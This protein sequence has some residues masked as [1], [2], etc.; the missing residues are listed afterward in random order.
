MRAGNKGY[1]T[2][3]S[4]VPLDRP[5]VRTRRSLLNDASRCCP[6]LSW[7]RYMAVGAPV[8]A[9]LALVLLLVTYLVI[10]PTVLGVLSTCSDT[11]ISVGEVPGYY[12]VPS[13][14]PQGSKVGVYW[15]KWYC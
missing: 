2:G 10:A 5:K 9:G 13:Y 12:L 15:W 4:Y 14:Y 1:S 11:D 8:L 6:C 3:G 7:A